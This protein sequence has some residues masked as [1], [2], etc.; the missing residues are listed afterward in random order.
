M[1][2]SLHAE[3]PL[4]EL[5]RAGL[6]RV[7]DYDAGLGDVSLTL[8]P[9]ELALMLAGPGVERHPLSDVISGLLPLDSGE[10]L[11]RGK[12][13]ADMNPDEQ[14]AARAKIGRVFAEHAW[15]SNLDVDENVTLAARYHGAVSHEEL[16]KLAGELARLVGLDAL[17]HTRPAVTDR[18]VLGRAQW[19]RAALSSPDL[20]LLDFPGFH[21]A[22]GWRQDLLPLVNRARAGGAA[23]LWWCESVEEWNDEILRPTL[24]WKAENNRIYT[25]QLS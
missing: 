8:Q 25:E 23:V 9:G 24:K 12:N 11:F 10:A 4:I 2:T 16:L 7:P 14:A 17:P 20:L 22:D 1:N 6:E 21:L 18:E 5:R 13:W 15:V 19:V 3:P